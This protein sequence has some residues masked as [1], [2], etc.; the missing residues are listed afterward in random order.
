MLRAV[1][2]AV[3]Q[4]GWSFE[5]VFMEFA[6]E[7]PWYAELEADGMTVRIAPAAGRRALTSW[8]DD[9][10]GERN[11]PTLLHTHFTAFDIP[12][13]MA[14]RRHDRVA[15]IWHLH[16][17]L[18]SN[19]SAV[20]RNTLKLALAGRRTDAILCVSEDTRMV[21]RRRLGPDSR[22]VTFPNAIDLERFRPAATAEERERSRAQLGVPAGIP[23][24]VHFGWDWERKGGDLFLSTVKELS[25]SEPAA[26]GVSVGGGDR[27]R[28]RSARLGLGDQVLVLEPTDDVRGLYSAADVFVSPSKAEGMPYAVLEALCTGTPAVVSDIPSHVPLAEQIAGC[29]LAESQP[30]AFAEAIRRTLSAH[31]DHPVDVTPLLE[32]LDLHGWASRLTD[33]Y[34]EIG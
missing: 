2:D 16:S 19:P 14:A 32:S 8:V 10:L 34:A 17:R 5:A 26:I 24:L 29:T 20:L 18:Q 9:L 3:R 33:L 21:A 25:H 22:L 1:E 28:A 13:V 27:A 7:R 15:V 6:A 12:A 31:D 23:L 30:Q 11:E 4:R